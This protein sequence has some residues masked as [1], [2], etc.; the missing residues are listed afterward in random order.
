MDRQIIS[1]TNISSAGYNEAAE[2]LEIEFMNGT[3]YQ[4]YNINIS[5]YEQFRQAS[6]KG[7]F[8]NTYIR[9]AYPYSRA[10]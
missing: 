1:S 8:L 7:Q 9:N 5:V 4:Y 2:I 10:G 6:S 3:V